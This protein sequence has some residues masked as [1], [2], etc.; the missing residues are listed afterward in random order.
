M[1]LVNFFL[2]EAKVDVLRFEI[3]VDD[4]AHSVQV[5]ESDQALLRHL[6]DDWKRSSFVVVSFDYFQQVAAENL[7]DRHEV[8]AVRSMV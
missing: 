4:L 2:G 3:R 7:E 1:D 8:L 5:V 6:P